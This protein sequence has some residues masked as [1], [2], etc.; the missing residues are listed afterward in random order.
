MEIYVKGKYIPNN[1]IHAIMSACGETDAKE[2]LMRKYRWNQSTII[3]IEWELHAQYIKKQTY[4]RN[5]TILKFIHR[6]LAS[7]NKNFG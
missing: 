6:W 2:F 1:Y 3:D 7:G 4:S 5:K